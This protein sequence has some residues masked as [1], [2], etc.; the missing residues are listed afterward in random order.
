MAI[1]CA[2]PLCNQKEGLM[3]IVIALPTMR[4]VMIDKPTLSHLVH[5]SRLMA[6][7]Q[8]DQPITI[9][10][11]E[12]QVK[13]F[14]ERQ[15][16]MVETDEPTYL[17]SESSDGTPNALCLKHRDSFMLTDWIPA[18]DLRVIQEA[19]RSRGIF[20]ADPLLIPVVFKPLGWRPGHKYVELSR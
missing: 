2:Y 16:V 17:I 12:D 15:N 13:D 3:L 10:H 7:M 18:S 5:D 4:T 1:K 11:H 19:A 6:Q 14:I 8:L 9:R 20:I